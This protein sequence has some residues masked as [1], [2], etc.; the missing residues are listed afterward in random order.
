MDSNTQK[1][2]SSGSDPDTSTSAAT[3][4]ITRS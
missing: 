3:T 2:P 1:C 4:G